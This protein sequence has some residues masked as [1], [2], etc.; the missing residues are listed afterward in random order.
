MATHVVNSKYRETQGSIRSRRKSSASRRTSSSSAP[1]L[2]TNIVNS[3]PR[4][5]MK[6]RTP[7]FKQWFGLSL[8]GRGVYEKMQLKTKGST[9]LWDSLRGPLFDVTFNYIELTI[10]LV[11]HR[12]HSQQNTRTQDAVPEL[13]SLILPGSRCCSYHSTENKAIYIEI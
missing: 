3:V 13:V 10:Y 12:E 8:S 7:T 1:E 5:R 6:I 11:K 2:K 9:V 4:E